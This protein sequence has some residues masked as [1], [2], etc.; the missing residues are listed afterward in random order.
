MGVHHSTVFRWLRDGA[1]PWRKLKYLS[2]TKAISWDWLIDGLEP[3]SSFKSPID[4]ECKET[5]FNDAE[6][7]ERFLSLF[8]G[9]TQ[10]EIA[11]ALEITP[12]A[13]HEW[14]KAVRRVSW[15]HLAFAVTHFNVRWDWLIDGVEPKYRYL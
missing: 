14:A 2:D 8:A 10:S 4:L 3:K 6:I 7:N 12:Q 9:M 1:I 11:R 5:D 13:V 15:S